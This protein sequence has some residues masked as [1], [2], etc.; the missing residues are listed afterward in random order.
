V[1]VEG[2]FLAVYRNYLLSR[3]GDSVGV[4]ARM[5]ILRLFIAVVVCGVAS[6]VFTGCLMRFAQQKRKWRWTF[7]LL[8]TVSI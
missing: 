4:I 6:S 2:T 5:A 1:R 7:R 8:G 3:V